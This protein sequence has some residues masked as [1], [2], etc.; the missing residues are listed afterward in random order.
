AGDEEARL[1]EGLASRYLW[2]TTFHRTLDDGLQTLASA[3]RPLIL[4]DRD[5]PGCAWRDAIGR[6]VLSSPE[7]CVVLASSVCDGYLWQEV[8]QLGG[9]DVITKPLQEEA[10]IQMLTLA[11]SYWR[12]GIMR[13]RRA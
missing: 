4:Y 11:W 10:V 6:L 13:G 8:V 2:R 5:V 1:V 9:Y 3:P 7:S 12:S